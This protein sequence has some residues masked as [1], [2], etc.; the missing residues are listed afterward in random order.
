MKILFTIMKTKLFP[1]CLMAVLCFP[2]MAYSQYYDDVEIIEEVVTEDWDPQ[3]KTRDS[4][5]ELSMDYYKDLSHWDIF[6]EPS[7]V[8]QEDTVFDPA[9]MKHAYFVRRST[10][11]PYPMLPTSSIS[12]RLWV[13]T[14]TPTDRRCPSKPMTSNSCK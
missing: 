12:P 14:C 2:L 13:R 4:L 6:I 10:L 1:L 8:A 5:R 11:L 9:G 3:Q 7:V